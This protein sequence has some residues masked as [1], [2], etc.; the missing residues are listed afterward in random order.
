MLRRQF[1]GTTI[2]LAAT[3]ALGLPSF[4][5]T[6]TVT[7]DIGR[8]SKGCSGFGICSITIGLEM[9]ADTARSISGTAELKGDLLAIKVR[10]NAVK[11]Q[12]SIIVDEAI[13]LPGRA[14]G[15]KEII[16]PA[17]TYPI[18]DNVIRLTVKVQ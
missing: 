4:A 10:P 15:V 14:F 13:T 6:I 12:Q 9:T 17:G 7:I 16:V 2:A 18:K 1:I 3:T 5:T 8:K 11:R